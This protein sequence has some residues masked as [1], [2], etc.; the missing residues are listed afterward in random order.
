MH[1][2][3]QVEN[4]PPVG[5]L[6]GRAFEHFIAQEIRAYLAYH[7]FRQTLGFWR[8]KHQQEVDFVIG[9]QVA[10]EVKSA[11]RVSERDHGGLVTIGGEQ[12]WSRRLIISQDPQRM[13]FANGIE[14]LWRDFLGELWAHQVL[15]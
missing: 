2:L 8:T 6:F 5:E 4:L 7:K 10:I 11:H 13:R 14:H 12:T 9:D 3:N 15:R 1:A